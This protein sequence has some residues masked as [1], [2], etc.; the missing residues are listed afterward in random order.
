MPVHLKDHLEIGKHIPGIIQLPR[1]LEV[2]LIVADLVLLWS[3]SQ[4]DEFQ[5]QLIHLPL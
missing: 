3:L 5:D 2:S 1:R 4:P